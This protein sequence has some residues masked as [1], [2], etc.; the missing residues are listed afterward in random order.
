MGEFERPLKGKKNGVFLFISS[1]SRDIQDFCIMQ[2]RYWLRHK[3]RQYG[4]Q[5]TK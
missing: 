4:S 2:I 1:R 3:V 5:N